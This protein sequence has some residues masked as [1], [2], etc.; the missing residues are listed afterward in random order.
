MLI[1]RETKLKI[2]K[3][4]L[5]D[6]V[7]LRELSEQFHIHTSNIKYYV[8]LYRAHGESVFVNDGE[9]R[10]YTREYKLKAIKRYMTGNESLRKIAVDLGLGNDI[11]TPDKVTISSGMKVW[12]KCCNGHTWQAAI[13]SRVSG[14][15]CPICYGSSPKKVLCI[16]TEI[17]YN[18]IL[19]AE[20][21]TGIN[22]GGISCCRGKQKSAGG[23]HWKF[24]GDDK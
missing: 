7:T 15:G 14:N 1:T 11:S 6:G 12:W 22:H 3:K 23:Y 17:E 9:L 13:H 8:D 18:S 24:I 16:E 20:K 10:T 2:V 5:K 19:E 21:K 4:H